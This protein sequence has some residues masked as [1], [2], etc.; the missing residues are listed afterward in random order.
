M[1]RPIIHNLKQRKWSFK[2][3]CGVFI[4]FQSGNKKAIQAFYQ[5]SYYTALV[6][7]VQRITE[8]PVKPYMVDITKYLVDGRSIKEIMAQTVSNN[9]KIY[10]FKNLTENIKSDLISCLLNYIFAL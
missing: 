1:L 9:I 5:L 7:K 6:I 3:R 8:R 2:C 4:T 10:W